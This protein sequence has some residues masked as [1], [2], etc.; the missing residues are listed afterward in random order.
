[1]EAATQTEKKWS[2]NYF[3]Q[4]SILYQ[5]SGFKKAEPLGRH[6]WQYSN[7]LFAFL[8]DLNICLLPVYIWVIEFL[9]ILCGLISPRFFDLLFYIMYGLLFITSVLGLGI[10]TARTHGQSFGYV[11]VN[12]KL[13]RSDLKEASA[14]VLIFRQ[15]LGFGLPLMIFGFLFETWGIFLWWAANLIC[16]LASPHQ[17]TIFDWIFH[18]VTVVEPEMEE[19][20]RK[21]QTAPAVEPAVKEEAKPEAPSNPISPIDLH[22]RSS[23]S[24]DGFFDVEEIFKQ[25]KNLGLEVISITDHNCTRQNAAAC[26]FAKLY[27]IQYIPG[28]EFDCQFKGHRIRILGYYIDWDNEIFDIL[29]RSSLKR[30]KE[31]SIARVKKFEQY[32]GIEIDV[33]SL[34][35]NS[36][37]QTITA[38][39]ITRMVFNNER[40]RSL[41]FVQKYLNSSPSERKAMKKFEK[42]IFAPGGPCYVKGDYP[43]VKTIIDAIHSANGMAILAAWHL[44]YLDHETLDELAKMGIDGI[45]CFSPELNAKQMAF[46]L[47]LVKEN[48][49]F[50]SAGS[51]FHGPTKP[52]RHMGDTKMPEKGE[53]LVRIFTTAAD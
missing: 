46:L 26:R 18:L 44:K 20:T 32:S 37:F 11:L 1:M 43:N 51:D 19:M 53:N 4:K 8:I 48:Q 40:T 16:V 6:F 49:L 36:R 35:S 2:Q 52:N 12:Y 28:A 38:R 22:I 25:A 29:E 47:K 9:L 21:N 50:V 15:A 3:Q 31:I 14:L 39:D 45:E 23:Y 5:K 41:P 13:V 27:D 17:Q 42:D 24:D 33:D 30:E 34:I 10:F 7:H